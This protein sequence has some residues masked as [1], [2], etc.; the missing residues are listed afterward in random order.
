MGR[1]FYNDCDH[2]GYRGDVLCCDAT[3][4]LNLW[5]CPELFWFKGEDG[6]PHKRARAEIDEMRRNAQGRGNEGPNGNY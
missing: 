1:C 4:I 6:F 2:A 3:P 5:V